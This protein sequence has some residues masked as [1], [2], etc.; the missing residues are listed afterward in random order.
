MIFPLAMVEDLEAELIATERALDRLG[1]GFIVDEFQLQARR[2]RLEQWRD[3][4]V[5]QLAGMRA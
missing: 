2:G 3:R 4:I 1:E 5:E